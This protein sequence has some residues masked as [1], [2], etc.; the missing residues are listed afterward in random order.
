MHHL[1]VTQIFRNLSSLYYEMQSTSLMILVALLCESMS[2]VNLLAVNGKPIGQRL[3]VSFLSL[4]Q[5][6]VVICFYDMTLLGLMCEWDCLLGLMHEWDCLLL[7]YMH[8]AYFSY[9]NDFQF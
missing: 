8:L 9:H 1:F 4:P 3:L 6:L 7:V 2:Q 5:N